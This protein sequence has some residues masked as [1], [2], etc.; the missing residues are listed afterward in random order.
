MNVFLLSLNIN[1]VVIL[2]IIFLFLFPIFL[3]LISKKIIY[4]IYIYTYSIMLFFGVFAHIL[5]K[6]NTVFISLVTTE[7]LANNPLSISYVNIYNI[8]INLLLFFPYGVI[9]PLIN[10]KINLIKLITFALV[11]SFFIEFLQ[12]LLPIIRYPEVLDVIT[13]IISVILGYT[14]YLL[15]SKILFRSDKDDKLSKQKSYYK[16]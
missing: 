10:T 7:K 14:Y 13:N 9:I 16:Q 8:A 1:L 5:I 2:T 3:T 6:N 15:I 4:K 12:F 11:L